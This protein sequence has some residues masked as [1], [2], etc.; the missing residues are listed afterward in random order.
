MEA[1]RVRHFRDS[2]E[3]VGHVREEEWIRRQ[4]DSRLWREKRGWEVN[5]GGQEQGR[6]AVDETGAGT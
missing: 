3:D 4:E 2:R 6:A 1:A 5:S